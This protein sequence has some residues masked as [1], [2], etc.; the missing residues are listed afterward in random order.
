MCKATTAHVVAGGASSLPL[1]VL[2]AAAPE[3]P[4]QTKAKNPRSWKD[5]RRWFC[6]DRLRPPPR[7]RSPNSLRRS[8]PSSHFRLKTCVSWS[9]RLL[10]EW[11][12]L[13]VL[14]SS[15]EV[16]RH[17]SPSSGDSCIGTGHPISGSLRAISGKQRKQHPDDLLQYRPDDLQRIG[18]HTTPSRP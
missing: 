10:S 8:L 11:Q 5:R 15:L 2:R 14:L 13:W 6:G 7:L 9:R 3:V 16:A 1:H 17:V 4:C 18:E 12:L